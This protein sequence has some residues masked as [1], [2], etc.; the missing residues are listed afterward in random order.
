LHALRHR[1]EAFHGQRDPAAV[2]AAWP[3]LGHEDRFV[4]YAAR[5]AI[6]HQDP[7]TWKERA[8][9]ET[10]PA[11]ALGAL[12]ALV[13]AT[14]QDPFHHPRKPGDPVPGAELESPILDALERLG[15]EKLTD[16]Q[17]LDLLRI[18]AVLF[19]RTGKPDETARQKLIARFDRQYPARGRELNADLCQLLVYLEAPDVVAKSLRLMAEA[20]T[21]E[22]QIEYARSLRVLAKGWTPTQRKEYFEWYRKAAN[23]KGGASLGGFFRLMKADAVAT[24]TEK[25]KAE[26]KPI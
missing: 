24:I 10:D 11:K 16:S 15:W 1:L 2:D 3:H 20:P 23:F 5:T 9:K 21:Q 25:E 26:L 7:K 19:N 13:R 22:E 14:T 6:E 17:R 12:L 18:Y 8:L 4:R